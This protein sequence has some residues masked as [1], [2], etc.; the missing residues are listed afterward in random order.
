MIAPFAHLIPDARAFL[1][2]LEQNNRKD[3]FDAHKAR[4]TDRIRR[5]GRGL[6][7]DP[8]RGLRPAD[9]SPSD[10]QGPS[11]QPRCALVKGQEPLQNNLHILWSFGAVGPPRLLLRRLARP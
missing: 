6:G 9:R 8:E 4:H 3:W 7:Q 1:A 2:E 10:A 5:A 11:H